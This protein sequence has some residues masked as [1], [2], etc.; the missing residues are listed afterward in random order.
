MSGVSAAACLA[1]AFFL[2]G[3]GTCMIDVD[4]CNKV[5]G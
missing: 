1:A 5:E 2:K 3:K 4:E